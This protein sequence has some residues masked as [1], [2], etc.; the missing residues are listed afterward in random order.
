MAVL[1]GQTYVRSSFSVS[2]KHIIWV[3]ENVGILGYIS[4]FNVLL[5]IKKYLIENVFRHRTSVHE[6][7]HGGRV[8]KSAPSVS[9]GKAQLIRYVSDNTTVL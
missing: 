8:E 6:E 9:A 5:I 4:I 7:R 2:G 1:K 3:H